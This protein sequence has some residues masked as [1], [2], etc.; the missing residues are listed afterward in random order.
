MGTPSGLA[1]DRNGNI[2]VSD[3][4]NHAVRVVR[5]NVIDTVAG[6][7]FPAFYGDGLEARFAFLNTPE[8]VAVDAAGNIFIA[9]SNNNRIRR[10]LLSTGRPA[11][12]RVSRTSIAFRVQQGGG[13]TYPEVLAIQNSGS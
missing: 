9:D 3:E 4:E 7:G 8:A 1:V 13:G 6:F 12:L 11:S 2:F 5:G 10:I